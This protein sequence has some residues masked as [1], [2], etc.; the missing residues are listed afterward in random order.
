MSNKPCAKL[1]FRKWSGH[2]VISNI[3]CVMLAQYYY[4]LV[5]N[6]EISI[7][8]VSIKKVSSKANL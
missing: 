6:L 7:K 3:L 4:K 5:L 1:S 8:K 2:Q